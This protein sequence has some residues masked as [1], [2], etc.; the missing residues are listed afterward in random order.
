MERRDLRG[1]RMAAKHGLL[2]RMHNGKPWHVLFCWPALAADLLAKQ[3]WLEIVSL[4]AASFG[5]VLVSR[6]KVGQ[7]ALDAS[8]L[9]LR[10]P[11]CNG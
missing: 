11:F 7:L 6:V 8:W 4:F 2:N 3:V 9:G 10:Q 5:L 1:I